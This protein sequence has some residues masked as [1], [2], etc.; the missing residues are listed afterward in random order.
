[1]YRDPR[2]QKRVAVLRAVDPALAL[3]RLAE[4]NALMDKAGDAES[5]ERGREHKQAA[6]EL[7]I[8]M[9]K[10]Q[11]WTFVGWLASDAEG[12]VD[13]AGEALGPAQP[14]DMHENE[15][16]LAKWGRR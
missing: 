7:W 14:G 16:H 8:S 9:K 1:M 6:S 15:D 5:P 12:V 2:T 10:E 11:A 13:E 3:R 4:W